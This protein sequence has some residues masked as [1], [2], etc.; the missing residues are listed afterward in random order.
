[1]VNKVLV[2]AVHPD[3]ETL[4]CGGTLL[5]HHAN[6][7]EIHW[8]I[9]TGM[10]P[11]TTSPDR[12]K[13]RQAEIDTVAR[14]FGFKSVIQMQ[15]ITTEVDQLSDSERVKRFSTI[16][17]E[18]QP[19]MVYLP[20][21]RDAHSDHRAVFEAVYSC[22]KSFR[23]PS[24]RTVYMMEVPSETDFSIPTGPGFQPNVWVDISPYLQKKL[25]ILSV[26]ESEMGTHPFPRSLKNCEAWATIRGAQAG[27]TYAESFMVL[28]QIL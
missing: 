25:D 2:V 21:L 13:S 27:C 20:F 12:I 6:G 3:D 28:K 18:L 17:S 14:K 19:T 15:M 8:C 24:I 22:T 9:V 11:A 26:F 7:D 23:Y 16:I 4:G 10:N 5:R 1:M